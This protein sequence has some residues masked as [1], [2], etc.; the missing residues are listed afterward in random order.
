MYTITRSTQI[1]QPV[2]S[3]APNEIKVLYAPTAINTNEIEGLSS[4]AYTGFITDLRLRSL[5]SNLP[6]QEIPD[7]PLRSSKT[8]KARIIR[9]WEYRSPRYELEMLLSV[10]NSPD[11]VPIFTF[12][13]QNRQPFFITNIL[14]YLTDQ[15]AFAIASN[16]TLGY[17]FKD[18]GYG[19]PDVN[20]GLVFYGSA[21]EEAVFPFIPSQQTF[22]PTRI[23]L[24]PT[25]PFAA[26]A[27]TAT[28]CALTIHTEL[29]LAT[30]EYAVSSATVPVNTN[31]ILEWN[32]TYTALG[33]IKYLRPTT[34]AVNGL[35][36]NCYTYIEGNRLK[37]Q[38]NNG[39]TS[40]SVGWIAGIVTFSF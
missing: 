3:Y 25:P 23:P 17:R 5:A 19:F 31:T 4:I 30:L 11:W 22:T 13:I 36:L 7:I 2:N 1:L 27:P 37:F 33:G 15:P 26:F 21:N 18:V 29:R 9:D 20:D 39:A 32:P 38:W 8:D 14:S 28:N 34:V 12:S 16:A 24:T 10:E 40:S 35:G 6:E